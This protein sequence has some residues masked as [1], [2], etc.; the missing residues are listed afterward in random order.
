M[1]LSFGI[2]LGLAIAGVGALLTFVT[3]RKS[4][5]KLIVGVGLTIALLTLVLIVLA[6]NA[7]M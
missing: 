5:A 1:P 6:V 3:N 7:R 2:L 4:M